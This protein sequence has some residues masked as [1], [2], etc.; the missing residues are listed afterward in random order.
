MR[1]GTTAEMIGSDLREGRELERVRDGDEDDQQHDRTELAPDRD[2]H[3]VPDD[4]PAEQSHCPA[5]I[6]AEEKVAVAT[7][8][9]R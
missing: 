9:R 5:G 4:Q 8:D 3:A 1:Y 7:R 2:E 6:A